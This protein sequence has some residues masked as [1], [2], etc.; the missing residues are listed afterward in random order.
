MKAG[1]CLPGNIRILAAFHSIARLHIALAPITVC[2]CIA[3]HAKAELKAQDGWQSGRSRTPGKR[4]YRK[5]TGV[6]IPPHPL[7]LCGRWQQATYIESPIREAICITL[8]HNKA[9]C[10]TRRSVYSRVSRFTEIFHLPAVDAPALE[11]HFRAVSKPKKAKPSED[12]T[13]PG[14]VMAAKIRAR[15]NKLTDSER[16]ALMGD[17]MRIIYGSE[18]EAARAHRR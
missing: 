17:A 5:V 15:A 10:V 7:C 14:T 6:R 16:G 1:A 2:R 4:V 8:L 3:T 13:T 11:M 18:G 9:A 12:A